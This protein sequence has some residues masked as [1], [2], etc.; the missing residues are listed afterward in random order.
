[1]PIVHIGGERAVADYGAELA[2]EL[3]NNVGSVVVPNA[4][5]WL[6]DEQPEAF[7]NAIIGFMT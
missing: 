5:H 7:S 1:M 3:A 2:E 6:V 4:G